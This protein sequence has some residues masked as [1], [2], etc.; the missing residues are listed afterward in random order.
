[1]PTEPKLHDIDP[2]TKCCRHCGI[3]KATLIVLGAPPCGAVQL[4][5]PDDEPPPVVIVE[6]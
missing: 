6:D 3:G 4:V 5:P 2:V 1:M